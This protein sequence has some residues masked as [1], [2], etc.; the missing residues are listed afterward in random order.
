MSSHDCND[1]HRGPGAEQAT[2]DT[3]SIAECPG[4]MGVPNSYC[5]RDGYVLYLAVLIHYI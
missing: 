2:G 1:D 4:K 5:K 3:H